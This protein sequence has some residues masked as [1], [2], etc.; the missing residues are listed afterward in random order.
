MS[1]SWGTQ[2]LNHITKFTRYTG[3]DVPKNTIASDEFR[4]ALASRYGGPVEPSPNGSTFKPEYPVYRQ[5]ARTGAS[6]YYGT[7][8]GDRFGRV[9]IYS[10]EQISTQELDE[11]RMDGQIRAGLM[12]MKLPI[13]RSRW[14]VNCND[15]DIANYVRE[16]LKPI[17]AETIRHILLMLDFGYM[18]AEVITSNRYGL[19]VTST[20]ANLGS[21]VV[22]RYP[23]ALV[24]DDVM[25]IDPLTLKLLAYNKSGKFAGFE[26]FTP[27]TCQVPESKAFH[28][29]NE[30]EFKELYGV[31]RTK[32]CYPYWLRKKAA[33]EWADIGYQQ[34][35][36]P[37]R[38]I[39]YPE[40]QIE[41]G[42]DSFGNPVYV[43]ASDIALQVGNEMD[44]RNVIAL[45]SGVYSDTKQPMWEA[46]FME[47]PFNGTDL[48]AYVDHQNLEILKSLLI[49][50]LALNTGS[51]GS[52]DLAQ[53]QMRTMMMMIETIQDQIAEALSS[54][55]VARVVKQMF[56]RSAPRASIVFQPLADDVKE[57]LTN[58][59][60]ETIG[61]GQPI[62]LVDGNQML[63]DWEAVAE[64]SGIPVQVLQEEDLATFRKAQESN[65]PPGQGAVGPD[66]QPLPGSE[67]NGGGGDMP[68][69]APPG[70]SGGDDRGGYG[71]TGGASRQPQNQQ[72]P[73]LD[74]D[75]RGP[76]GLADIMR[77]WDVVE[78]ELVWTPN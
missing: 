46:E 45:P 78:N 22:K 67:Q 76:M 18:V 6:R 27:Q 37:L 5:L 44:N 72:Q 40:L 9:Y 61:Q 71:T 10:P 23:V 19:E 35:S 16:I 56:G 20:Q 28:I 66:G 69:G 51:S 11:M 55:I 13:I 14:T 74:D 21:K 36:V 2:P 48:L 70:G 17:W 60:F 41:D 26:Q 68:F 38:K 52:Y 43:N 47:A 31:P 4:Q 7:L 39:R 25:E 64:Y 30:M 73:N 58:V 15:K 62:P 77:D 57:G 54:Q 8:R 59:L 3:R 75:E 42:T 65:Q 29:A 12:L 49:P 33:Y 50:E 53:E 24:V 63:V 32:P 1:P 34:N